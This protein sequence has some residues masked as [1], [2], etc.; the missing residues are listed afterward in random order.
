LRNARTFCSFFFL[1]LLLLFLLLLLLPLTFRGKLCVIIARFSLCRTHAGAVNERSQRLD[2]SLK[3]LS[4]AIFSSI[5]LVFRVRCFLR[6]DSLF[7][8]S[9]TIISR[10]RI[11]AIFSSEVSTTTGYAI[12]NS[13]NSFLYLSFVSALSLFI[14]RNPYFYCQVAANFIV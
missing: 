7:S 6:I 12:A 14:I 10:S 4:N 8:I 1:L 11:S 9:L 5:L 2:K 13:L 3:Y